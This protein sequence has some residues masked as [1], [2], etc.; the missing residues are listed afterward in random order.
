M[1]KVMVPTPVPVRAPSGWLSRPGRALSWIRS[2]LP[3][4]RH[5]WAV[6]GGVASAPTITMAALMYMLFSRPLLTP[7]AFGSYV[8]WKVSAL[9][10]T[11][12]TVGTSM[13]M[14]SGTLARLYA[15]IGPVAQSPLL[16][17]VGGVFF[18]LLSAGALWVLYRNLIVTPSDNRYARARV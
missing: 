15:F 1:T 7:S 14:E 11:L 13:A 5:G 2:L 18:S 3:T 10:E 16:L 12:V 8:F 17:G 6:A 4:T 9:L